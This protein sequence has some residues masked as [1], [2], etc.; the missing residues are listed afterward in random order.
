MKK[1]RS[2]TVFVL[3]LVLLSALWNA[4]GDRLEY[5]FRMPISPRRLEMLW[6]FSR[7]TVLTA[8]AFLAVAVIAFVS[9]FRM[10]GGKGKTRVAARESKTE[11]ALHCEH[12][13]G[14]DKYLEQIDGYLRTGLIDRNEYRVLKERY[15]R[16]DIPDD[17]H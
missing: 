7:P 11:E 2:G 4:W 17:Y 3:S 6:K 14:K 8:L 1:N 13:N 16:I 10:F 15:A 12:L 9:F 5:L